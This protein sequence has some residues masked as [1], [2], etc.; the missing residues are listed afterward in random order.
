MPARKCR[1]RIPTIMYKPVSDIFFILSYQ[2]K[3]RFKTKKANLRGWL[4]K[5]MDI[6]FSL[7]KTD[8]LQTFMADFDC[9]QR[10]QIKGIIL[11]YKVEFHS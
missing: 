6:S 8:F 11:L 10:I 4:S 1:I 5:L 2:I 7:F 9:F 3:Q